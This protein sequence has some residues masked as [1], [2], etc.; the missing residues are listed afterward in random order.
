MFRP[1]HILLV[2][3]LAIAGFALAQQPETGA[4]FQAD[5]YL[6]G[7][8]YNYGAMTGKFFY[9]WDQNSLRVEFNGDE[10][11]VELFHYNPTRGTKGNFRKQYEYQSAKGEP[12]GGTCQTASLNGDMPPLGLDPMGQSGW[13]KRSAEMIEGVSCMKYDSD[14]D[15][16]NKNQPESVWMVEGAWTPCRLQYQSGRIF[17][18]ENVVIPEGKDAFPEGENC[19]CQ[20]AL[21]VILLLDG[22]SSISADEWKLMNDYVRKVI[23][24]FDWAPDRAS[25]AIVQFSYEETVELQFTPYKDKLDK[26][27]ANDMQK[28]KRGTDVI[29]GLRL[30]RSDIYPERRV[31][32]I[33][34]L[35]TITDGQDRNSSKIIYD[36]ILEH[37]KAPYN[38]K[39]FISIFIGS[40]SLREKTVDQM[41][42]LADNNPERTFD[43]SDYEAFNEAVDEIIAAACETELK[44]YD[45]GI[46]CCGFCMCTTCVSPEL[47]DDV[48]LCTN[49][50]KPRVVNDKLSCCPPPKKNDPPA[51]PDACHIAVCDSDT[52]AWSEVS[53]LE[54]GMC[55]APHDCMETTCDPLLGCQ[56]KCTAAC[57]DVVPPPCDPNS[58]DDSNACTIDTASTG[59]NGETVCT[60]VATPPC[61]TNECH[62]VE[63]VPESGCVLTP[64]PEDF[65]DDFDACTV[66][67]CHNSTGCVNEPVDDNFCDDDNGCTNDSCHAT[68]GC[69]NEP[70]NCP[71]ENDCYIGTC[72]K[73]KCTTVKPELCVEEIAAIAGGTIG[74]GFIILIVV[75][76]A[77]CLLGS[78]AAVYKGVEAYNAGADLDSVGVSNPLY[79]EGTIRGEN[80]L[81]NKY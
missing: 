41:L 23:E 29:D 27:M 76:V 54:N 66:D 75:G 74:A 58:C 43:Y 47:C 7:A 2:V 10:E 61:E 50:D 24:K 67:T 14:S 36:E 65:C 8:A 64:V 15:N 46:G 21:D 6:T 62:T 55:S 17:T 56:Y 63:C 28:H 45:C 44:D 78:A 16:R 77:I 70:K 3:L 53:K 26:F 35:I 39:N 5:F 20:K 68:K 59:E 57:A 11:Y 4:R 22:S 34:I 73:D 49:E 52:G 80:A 37:K 60:Y 25:L 40:D 71:D 69:L 1:T 30:I 9:D 42:S 48:D 38:V 79:E 51:E 81:Y 13:I 31:S 33:P 32:A 72:E 12:C 18:F 19:V